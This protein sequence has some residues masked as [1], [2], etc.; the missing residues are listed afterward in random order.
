MPSEDP[1]LHDCRTETGIGGMSPSE[2]RPETAVSDG[3]S[4]WLSEAGR[5]KEDNLLHA[6][7]VS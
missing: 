2:S 1:E 3:V 5:K 6:F 7:G 4:Q